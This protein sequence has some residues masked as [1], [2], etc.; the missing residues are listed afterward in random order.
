MNK[1]EKCARTSITT[2][3]FI[4]SLLNAS[5]KE[6]KIYAN[7]FCSLFFKLTLDFHVYAIVGVFD[8]NN[9]VGVQRKEQNKKKKNIDLLHIKTTSI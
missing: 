7:S 2:I 3:I 9:Q 4:S 5:K 8:D 1:Y 6:N